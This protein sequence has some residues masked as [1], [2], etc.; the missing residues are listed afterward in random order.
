MTNL[1]GGPIGGLWDNNKEAGEGWNIVR[2]R[3]KLALVESIDAKPPFACVEEPQSRF[4]QQC[5]VTAEKQRLTRGRTLA[6]L[7]A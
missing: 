7:P 3:R 5:R 6:P 2:I 4:L 1:N